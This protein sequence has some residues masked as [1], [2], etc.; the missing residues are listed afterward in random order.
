MGY[1]A[2][3]A[4]VG[5]GIIL[6]AFGTA[7]CPTL[8]H[9]SLDLKAEVGKKLPLLSAKL[10]ES[11]SNQ[12]T[13]ESVLTKESSK[14]D[15]F[16]DSR[17]FEPVKK[18]TL[19]NDLTENNLTES[20]PI[21]EEIETVGNS[22]GPNT[23]ISCT[24]GLLNYYNQSDPRWSDTPYG[25]TDLLKTHGCGPTAVAMVISSFTPY[26]VT[27]PDMASWASEHGY[28]SRGEGSLHS[29]I[30]DA[31]TFYG[32]S[33]HPLEERSVEAICRELH[34]GKIIIALMNKGFFTQSG[35]FLILTE[36]TDDGLL[37]LAD[38]ASWDNTKMAW[39]PGF[40]LT[41]VRQSA[42]AGGPLWVVSLPSED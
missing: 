18:E 23:T 41:Q 8:K 17:Y 26:Q 40:I 38:P 2:K 1:K 28:C 27:P 10:S 20:P 11:V 37:Q 31:L 5:F 7:S 34:Q 35:H 15:I 30:P 42:D 32:F 29:L 3:L 9:I 24:I 16:S 39:N 4:A 19:Q 6:L 13:G 25:D 12:E 21:F 36:V 22:Y 33:V 14:E